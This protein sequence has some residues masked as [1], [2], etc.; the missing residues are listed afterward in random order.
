MGLSW[1]WG[2][3]GG[4]TNEMDRP[5]NDRGTTVI[6]GVHCNGLP[7]SRWV[8]ASSWVV[9]CSDTQTKYEYHWKLCINFIYS[10][11]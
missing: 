9:F 2:G 5:I 4:L 3:V 11:S 10:Y 6:A 7:I 8:L 1:G